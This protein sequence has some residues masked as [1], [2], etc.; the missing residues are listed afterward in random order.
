LDESDPLN[1]RVLI[2][3][4]IYGPSNCVASSSYY[5]VC[6]VDE[7][8]SILGRIEQLVSAPEA[9]PA[10]ILNLV[11]M[12]ASATV[13]SNRT[14]STWLQT[15]LHEVAEH[16]GG[17]VP[18][19]GRLFMQWLHYAYPR[20]CSFPHT[21]GAINPQLAEDV[22]SNDTTTEADVSATAAVMQEIVAAAQ[23]QKLRVHGTEADASEESGMW[24][25]D[26]E[27]VVWRQPFQPS[28]STLG[29][30]SGRR[31]ALLAAALSFAIAGVRS[32]QPLLTGSKR[33]SS[34]KYWV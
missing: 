31:V 5:S 23:P 34:D 12:T 25:M 2:P 29:S 6:C 30:V 15:R 9:S 18:L 1:L 4:Y 14:L 19:H 20:E 11:Q 3:N 27:L 26:E 21:L 8:E 28:E 24:S 7:C 32:I 17:L 33:A 10:T 22:L 13:P 16:H